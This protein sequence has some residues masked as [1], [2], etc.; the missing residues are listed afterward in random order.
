A[1]GEPIRF[2]LVLASSPDRTEILPRSDAGIVRFVAVGPQG[3]QPGQESPGHESPVA[4]LD[5]RD[6]AGFLRPS[7][8][9]WY[10]ILYESTPTF[11]TLAPET[12]RAYL[13]E[14]GL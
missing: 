14:K 6:P 3:E 2:H 12:F 1:L 5:G 11:A 8:A 4:G 13:L 9:G 10:T 7:A